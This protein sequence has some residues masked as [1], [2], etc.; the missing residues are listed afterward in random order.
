MPLL[1]FDVGDQARYNRRLSDK[2]LAAFDHA[3]DDGDI[4]TATELLGTLEYMLLSTPPA[5]DRCEAVVAPLLASHER[6]W[7]LKSSNMSVGT[8]PG[9]ADIPIPAARLRLSASR[10]ELEA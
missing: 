2:I 9:M 1:D 7:H 5:Q 8:E 3:C 6:L 4:E 10:S